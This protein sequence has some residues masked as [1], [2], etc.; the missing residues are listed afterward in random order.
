MALESIIFVLIAAFLHALWNAFVNASEDRLFILGMIATAHVIVGTVLAILQPF[1]SIDSWYFIAASTII[2]FGYYFLI[3]HSY[4]L[5]DL[6][7]VYPIARGMAPVIVAVGAQI[8]TN[9]YLPPWAWGGI[10]ITSIGIFTLSG[11]ILKGSTPPIA[12]LTAV[13]T[14]VLIGMYS[15]IDGMGVRVS[16]SALSYIA[17][18]FIGEIFVSVFV[19]TYLRK[20]LSAVSTKT[21]K[22]GIIGGFISAAAYG[23]VIYIKASEPL[24]LVSTF[25]E[26]SVVFATLIGILWL[27][28]R[29]WRLKIF[30]SLIVTIGVVIMGVF[31]V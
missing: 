30:A 21:I 19:F 11:S 22:L 3:Y 17:W 31:A 25:R 26:T 8:F 5:G 28:E 29:P 9:E 20:N 4:R 15:L 27:G 13:L 16:G 10:I 6:S 23:I 2:H 24:G 12:I 1:P 18:L 14:G 7:D